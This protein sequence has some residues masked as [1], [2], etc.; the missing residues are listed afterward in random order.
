M[1]ECSLNN[2]AKYYGANKIFENISFE[3]KS[4]ERVGLIGQNGT[5][6]TSLMKVLTGQEEYQEG[7]IFFRK[8]IKIG[9]L[10]QIFNYDNEITV[11]EILE[12]AFQNIKEIRKQMRKL[13]IEMAELTD[14]ELEKS[15]ERY[16]LLLEEYEEKGGYDIDMEINMVCEGLNIIESFRN[17]KFVELSGG[18][19]TRIGLGKLLLEKPD[20]LLMDEPT[21][22]LDIE[23]IEWL[24]GFLQSYAGTVLIIS[25]DRVFLDKVVNRIIELEPRKANIYEGN[26]S[27]Y[28]EEKDRRFTQ[29]YNAYKNQQKKI[30]QM[31]RQIERYRI[32]G[33]MRDSDK[34]YVRAKELEKRLDKIDVLDRPDMDSRKMRLNQDTVE[35]SGKR[36]LDIENLSKSF[37]EKA[38]FMNVDISIFYQDRICI[39]GANGSGKSTLLKIILGDIEPDSGTVKLGASL[40]IGYLP[41]N[42]SFENEDISILDYFMNKHKLTNGEARSELAKVLFLRDDVLKRIKML[43]GGEKSRLKLA[44]LLFEKVNFMILDEPTNHL[45]IDSREVLEYTLLNYSGTILFVSHDRYFVDKIADKIMILKDKKIKTYNMDYKLYLDEIEKEKK[46]IEN[47]EIIKTKEKKENKRPVKKKDR[48]DKIKRLEMEIGNLENDLENVN[49]S[50]EIHS[51]NPEELNELFIKKEILEG[52]L[53]ELFTTWAEIMEE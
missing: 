30:E 41:Q 37:N 23:S 10:D 49:N 9:Y 52:K 20:L 44:S 24:E 4:N 11:I 8:D 31:E 12:S 13:E 25:H 29:E 15:M 53:E 38:L 48:S 35:R 6:K 27:Y 22:H 7:E 39:M 43:S 18:E 45:D 1:I 3:L 42:V 50:M 19:Q 21:N 40:K 28:L 5:G 46:T 17:R 33:K 26:Y 51:S 47:K 16:S 34:M 14:N 2:I 32:W 36:V